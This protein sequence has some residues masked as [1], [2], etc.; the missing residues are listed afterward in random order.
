MALFVI[1]NTWYFQLMEAD[2][3]RLISSEDNIKKCTIYL[4]SPYETVVSIKKIEPFSY[5][6]NIFEYVLHNEAEPSWLNDEY[7]EYF[8]DGK[9]HRANG[10]ARI[11][12][13]SKIKFY[14]YHGEQLR[15]SQ[16]LFDR[17]SPEEKKKAIFNLD[18]F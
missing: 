7:E 12:L 4:N 17:L 2:N 5:R 14:F 10:P 3:Y 16:D 13:K 9:R 15:N 18:S 1:D 6:G 8:L 11:F